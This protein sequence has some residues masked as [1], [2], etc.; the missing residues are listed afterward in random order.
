MSNQERLSL[1]DYMNFVTGTS[2]SESRLKD[3]LLSNKVTQRIHPQVTRAA[4]LCKKY[5]TKCVLLE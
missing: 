5:F 1:V 3:A 4:A 2:Q